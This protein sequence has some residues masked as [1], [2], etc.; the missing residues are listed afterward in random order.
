MARGRARDAEASKEAILGAANEV[1]VAH[2]FRGASVSEI[3][4]GAGLAK[5]T[6]FLHFGSKENLL[7]ALVE[8]RFAAVEELYTRT[9][10][11]P[12]MSALQQLEQLTHAE[13]WLKREVTDMSRTILSMWAGLPED[14]RARLE[15]LIRRN[16]ALF[17]KRIAGLFRE[18]LGAEEVR[19]VSADALAAAL[20]AS[21]D[22]M[23]VRAR[24]SPTLRPSA[25]KVGEALRLVFVEGLR[26]MAGTEKS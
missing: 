1:F 21:L 6:V 2:G 22:G 15:G 3:A 25:R 11:R 24:V 23:T 26:R 4:R 16:Y 5:G 8:R 20:M 9:V 17:R 18:L 14:L 7:Y 19:G 13:N 10:D 12:E